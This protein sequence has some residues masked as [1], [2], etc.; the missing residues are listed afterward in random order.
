MPRQVRPAHRRRKL[1][2]LHLDRVLS[3]AAGDYDV[4]VTAVNLTGAPKIS[5]N[6]VKI[7]VGQTVE[8]VAVMKLSLSRTR[9]LVVQA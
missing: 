9:L 8:K 5:F 1:L 4:V 7:A 3:L 2:P 6:A